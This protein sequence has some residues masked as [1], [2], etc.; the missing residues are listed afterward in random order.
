MVDNRDA[1]WLARWLK[2]PD[3]MLNEKDPLATALFERYG[4]VPMPN[5][6]LSDK[7][8]AGSDDV[9]GYLVQARGGFPPG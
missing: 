6:R 8:S 3:A 1:A 4:R 2:E 7:K 5:L 9:H